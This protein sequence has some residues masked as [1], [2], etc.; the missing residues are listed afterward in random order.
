MVAGAACGDDSVT[1][2]SGDEASTERSLVAVSPDTVVA[3]DRAT[4]RLETRDAAGRRVRSGGRAVAFHAVGAGDAGVGV[5]MIGA[6]TDNR[7]GTYEADF[8]GTLVGAPLGIGATIDGDTVSTAPAAIRVVGGPAH[9][10]NT[11][12]R[13]SSGRLDVGSSVVL[14]LTVR[15]AEG[16]PVGRG[17]ADVAFATSGGTS[18]GDIGG[19]VDHGDGRYTATFTGTSVGTPLVVRATLGGD[20]VP[21]TDT[22]EVVAGLPSSANSELTVSADSVTVGTVVQILLRAR[23]AEGRLLARGGREVTF[24][25]QTGPGLSDGVIEADSVDL[26]DGSY[27][28]DFHATATGEPVTISATIDGQPLSGPLPTIAV[29]DVDPSALTSTVAVADTA[30]VAGDSTLVTLTVS[31]PDGTAVASGGLAVAFE[32]EVGAG[33]SGGTFGATTDHDDGTYSA[34]FT[35]LVAGGPVR[36]GAT[37]DG[38]AVQMLD[39]LGVSLLPT[40]EVDPGPVS[41]DAS[42]VEVSDNALALGDVAVLGLRTRDAFGNPLSTGGLDVAF[43]A[44]ADVV[45]GPVGSVGAVSDIGDGSYEALYTATEEV[46][47]QIRATIGG[48]PVADSVAIVSVCTTGAVSPARS[49]ITVADSALRSGVGT[50]VTLT[51]RDSEGRCLRNTGLAVAFTVAGGGSAGSLSATVDQGDGTYSSTFTGTLAGSPSTLAASI[52]GT[53][54]TSAAPSVRVTPG[55]VSAANSLLSVNR[56][57]LDVG[58]TSRIRLETFDAAGNALEEGGLQIT[59]SATGGTGGGSLS[60]VTDEADGG[61]F[62]DFTAASVGTPLTIGASIGGNPVGGTAPTIAVVAG[63][64]SADSSLIALQGGAVSGDTTT[65]AVGD[66]IAVVL[67]ARD[68]EGRELVGGGYSVVFTTEGGTGVV[69][70]D[71]SPA[72]DTNDG[73]YAS[74]VVGVASG[75]A[76]MIGATVDGQPVTQSRPVLVVE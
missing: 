40:I 21:M 51:A 19:A 62:A 22:I 31:A 3:G 6:T 54:V 35:G 52:D 36:I 55:D 49:T 20:D 28:A 1:A 67:T 53:P 72:V 65:I 2:P 46:A 37:M 59:F 29:L 7:D 57:E 14:I 66:T 17:G 13:A 23:D 16:R 4:V 44:T 69:A 5:G 11:E 47:A 43:L 26:G 12:L 39:T 9:L 70:I 56:A 61:Y 64:V 25:V 58:R 34:A 73:T 8:T 33:S 74:A 30:L 45:G 50:T 38:V 63:R 42:F 60:P 71:P 76:V 10:P 18:Q 15:D 75:T 68:A 41:L 32:A 24:S 48:Q 27:T